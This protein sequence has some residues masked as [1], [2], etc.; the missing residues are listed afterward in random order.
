MSSLQVKVEKIDNGYITTFYAYDLKN[1][2]NPVRQY[3]AEIENV[4]SNV[5]AWLDGST[6]DHVKITGQKK[7]RGKPENAGGGSKPASPKQVKFVLGLLKRQGVR[8]ALEE[9]GTLDGIDLDNLSGIQAN[10][11]IKKGMADAGG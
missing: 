11:I 10:S 5:A 9:D 3:N 6:A 1:P 4:L 8:E 7:F 2:S